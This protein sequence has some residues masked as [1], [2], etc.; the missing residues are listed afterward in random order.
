M[1]PSESALEIGERDSGIL[2][3]KMSQFPLK[4]LLAWYS[5]S[6]LSDNFRRSLLLKYPAPNT[7]VLFQFMFCAISCILIR[8][9]TRIHSLLFPGVEVQKVPKKV[10]F[11]AAIH[12]FAQTCGTMA[13]SLIEVSLSQTIR[14]I[15][16]LFSV[17]ISKKGN[18]HFRKIFT[19]LPVV[20]SVS[21]A[22]YS[23]KQKGLGCVFAL[24]ATFGETLHN[25]ATKVLMDST[26]D[27]R[28]LMLSS[29]LL[30][31]LFSIPLITFEKPSS[32]WFFIGALLLSVGHFAHT[33]LSYHLIH[34]FTPL[35]YSLQVQW[36]RLAVILAATLLF[37][38]K[39]SGFQAL[40]MGFAFFGLAVHL[41]LND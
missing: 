18:N 25:V 5:I 20:I 38:D 41:Y 12:L 13:A 17:L 29:A 26:Q 21:A 33:I 11:I 15:S 1:I 40:F 24:L 16:P 10:V 34:F 4:K 36:R 23:S 2:I 37:N 27:I 3:D 28:S 31:G 8:P 35:E 30:S 39:L 7:I 14:T 32:T 9:Q 6:I 22:C 19:M